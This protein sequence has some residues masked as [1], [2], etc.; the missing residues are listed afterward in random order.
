MPLFSYKAKNKKG[1]VVQDVLQAANRQEAASMLKSEDLQVLTIKNLDSGMGSITFGGISVSEKAS[2]C[3]FLGTMLKAGLPVSEAIEIIVGETKNKKFQRILFDLSFQI[4]KGASLSGVLSKYKHE[5]SPVFLTMVKAG[6]ESGTLDKSFDYLAKQLL[7]SY[8]LTQKVKGSL[9]YP[10]V[11]VGAM[12]ANGVVM[13]VFVLPKISEVFLQL[14]ANIPPLT[15]MVLSFGNFVGNNLFL[16]L[17]VFLLSIILVV[18]IFLISATRRIVFA[19]FVKLPV[20]SGMI[21][22]I[23]VARFARTLSTLL[24]SGVPIMVALEVSSNV[25]TEPKLKAK[26]KEFGKGVERGESLSDVLE[27][28]EKKVFP[29]TM[30]QTIKAG[31]KTGTLEI[32]LA[33]MADFY[34]KEVDYSLKRLTA[35]LEPVLM[36]IIGVAVGGMVIMMITP[37]YSI[38]GAI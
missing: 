25:L 4:R 16:V 15:K 12:I 33:E 22:Q 36:L 20:V 14:D 5:F 2:F 27:K 31:E 3:R 35:L 19:L 7:A 26:A 17:G 18:T 30:S 6:E 32:V 29:V 23:D 11:I 21:K 10:I 9:M 8:E 24:Q 28:G 38:I 13:I 37:I 34:E 1:K